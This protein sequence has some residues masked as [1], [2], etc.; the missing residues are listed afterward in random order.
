M[1]P[2]PAPQ[3]DGSS[4]LVAVR[5]PC[6]DGSTRTRVAGV[7]IFDAL[8]DASSAIGSPGTFGSR[9]PRISIANTSAA[10]ASAAFHKIRVFRMFAA[11]WG[12]E[13]S[14][15]VT[16]ETQYWSEFD[17]VM[18]MI[19]AHGLHVIPSI[20]YSSWWRT[21]NKAFPGVNETLNDFIL[22]A[23]S[24]SRGLATKYFTQ[25]VT[26]YA[27]RDCV[28]LWELGNVRKGPCPLPR[29]HCVL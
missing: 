18:D 4:K 6:P 5:G 11:L 22:N 27:K 16:N 2:P 20:G 14:F 13:M 3:V 12:P 15:W 23:S 1:C 19:A 21:A 8:W 17:A 7:N 28:L 9:G 24:V 25:I 29:S 26:R 10:L